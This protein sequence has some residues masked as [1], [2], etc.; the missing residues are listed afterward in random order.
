[1]VSLI[2]A[3]AFYPS[4]GIWSLL[5]L[6]GGFLIDIDHYFQYIFAFKSFDMKKTYAYYK[7]N[8]KNRYILNG[9]H[10][11]EFFLLLVILLN[12]YPKQSF[13]FLMGYLPHM[14]MDYI[15][16]KKTAY[17]SYRARSPSILLWFFH[18]YLK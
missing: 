12:F 15:Y 5:I 17:R 1:M 11:V 14:L 10:T 13:L 8:L 2:L 9:F 6:V 18:H 16:I 7:S 4:Y 3:I